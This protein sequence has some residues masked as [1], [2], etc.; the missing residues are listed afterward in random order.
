ME[1]SISAR[2]FATAVS[3]PAAAG[4]SRRSRRRLAAARALRARHRLKL[5]N[6]AKRRCRLPPHLVR[7]VG[8]VRVRATPASA[9]LAN[10]AR[11]GVSGSSG[12]ERSR[13]AERQSFPSAATRESRRRR[14]S[15]PSRPESPSRPSL[16]SRR[17]LR[18]AC[19]P[20]NVRDGELAPRLARTPAPR[21][22][23]RTARD[24]SALLL[25]GTYGT[26]TRCTRFRVAVRPSGREREA[27]GTATGGGASSESS[28]SRA[29]SAFSEKCHP[30]ESRGAPRS[31]AAARTQ[32][33]VK[34]ATAPGHARVRRTRLR[35]APRV[36]S[37]GL[38]VRH[39]G[40]FQRRTSR[41]GAVSTVSEPRGRS[42]RGG[43]S[44]GH[45]GARGAKHAARS[46]RTCPRAPGAAASGPRDRPGMRAAE[47]CV[48][49][50]PS[51]GPGVMKQPKRSF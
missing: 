48:V 28:P 29:F 12:E 42:A 9:D 7:E 2:M 8:H 37:R 19:A 20:P 39:A 27:T 35:D 13:F 34:R 31:E 36:L 1:A 4:G 51:R 24:A 41:H 38:F 10:H 17:S 21:A 43:S 33:A 30:L 40:L 26:S 11:E 49:V 32:R 22:R 46:P 6:R 25:T 14:P 15:L 45:P 18:S 47:W 23:P 50:S 3:A 5:R 16:P 44:A